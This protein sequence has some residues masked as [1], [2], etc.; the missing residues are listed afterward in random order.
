MYVVFININIYFSKRRHCFCIQI[1]IYNNYTYYCCIY[2]NYT[3][4]CFVCCLDVIVFITAVGR[5]FIIIL[6]L[7][8]CVL[9]DDG[10]ST[11]HSIRQILLCFRILHRVS[12]PNDS[13]IIVPTRSLSPA[14]IIIPFVHRRVRLV[15][16]G[17]SPRGDSCTAAAVEPVTVLRW[18]C[19]FPL[20]Y[21]LYK[22]L[23]VNW[24]R[25][26]PPLLCLLAPL[27][28]KTGCTKA[29]RKATAYP[30]SRIYEYLFR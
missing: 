9:A 19:C 7:L 20:N 6:L 4:C 26:L 11:T 22:T 16:D 8:L 3:C 14:F 15:C 27:F 29:P 18:R 23:S 5:A 12:R 2:N 17:T 25:V 28:L 1:N 10:C 24:L 13:V 30:L 21:H